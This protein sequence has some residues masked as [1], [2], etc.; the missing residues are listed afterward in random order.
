ML[1]AGRSAAALR[2]LA[3]RG[4]RPAGSC[5]VRFSYRGQHLW[6]IDYVAR[7]PGLAVSTVFLSGVAGTAA[8]AARLVFGLLCLGSGSSTLAPRLSGSSG[9][10]CHRRSYPVYGPPWPCDGP[11]PCLSRERLVRTIDVVRELSGNP[12]ALWG[13]LHTTTWYPPGR[14]RRYSVGPV[15]RQRP[16][17]NC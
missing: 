11:M 10:F 9:S 7:S 2:Y 1:L 13:P 15:D 12:L 5:L 3:G 16:D 8:M 6:T 17:R 4:E 14:R